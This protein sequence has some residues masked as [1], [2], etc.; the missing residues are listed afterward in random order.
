MD[1]IL[2]VGI[3]L[4]TTNSAVAYIDEN[5]APRVIP[6]SEDSTLTPSVVLIDGDQVVVGEDAKEAM[7]SGDPNAVAFF[8]RTMG[9]RTSRYYLGDGDYSAVDLST[10]VLKKLKADAEAYLGREVTHAVIT[11]PAYFNDPQRNDT[12][13]AGKLAGIE[14]LEII[15][16]PTAAGF[17][18]GLHETG[19]EETILV[20]D[21]GGGTFDVTVVRLSQ[22]QFTALGTSGDH[23]LGGKDWDDSIARLIIEK[24][25]QEFSSNPLQSGLAFGEVLVLAE[26]AKR[27]LTGVDTTTITLNHAGNQLRFDLT[28]EEFERRTLD[29]L[30]T[31]RSLS[32]S[33]L[34]EIGLS[35]TDLTGVLLVGGSTRMPMIAEFIQ[36]VS[37]KDPLTG[38]NQDHAVAIGAA[39]RAARCLDERSPSQPR[40]RLPGP[41]KIIDVISHPL[42]MIAESQD[43]SKYVNS[44][45]LNK[46]LPIPSS[47]TRPYQLF[48]QS[49][50]DNK[51]E[52]F[53]TQGE[54]TDPAD[55]TVIARWEATGIEHHSDGMQIIDV[56]YG[57]TQ[58]GTVDV[59]ASLRSNGR[60]LAMIKDEELGDLSWM[61]EAPKRAVVSGHLTVYM[62]ID[63]SYSME[64]SGLRTA[65]AAARS[66][67]KEL[68]MSKSSVG[69]VEFADRTRIVCDA[70]QNVR[71]LEGHIAAMTEH[72]ESGAVGFAN[73]ATPLAKIQPAFQGVDGSKFIIVLTDGIWVHQDRAI[74]EAQACHRDGIEIIAVGT[75][76]ADEAFLKRL[77]SSDSNALYA[78]QGQVV[79]TFNTIARELTETGGGAKRGLRLK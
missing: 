8:K 75:D 39:V 45:I 65:Q 56:E 73:D 12:I 11:V 42:G 13:K 49:D 33:M 58:N 7:R 70:C 22:D 62:A 14:V 41:A 32:E 51:L 18:Y 27:K 4:G 68:D 53:L 19:R 36:S 38:I 74:Q 34:K 77:A 40:F 57:Y 37:G 43:G 35:W 17:A 67:L 72:L 79:S 26:N 10:F 64:G 21:L 63:L 54:T 61:F 23:Q 20:Y 5:S 28:R 15:N 31:T 60:Q 3:D 78:Q 16:E 30:E 1:T 66:F 52:V 48:T 29:L 44:V 46:N 76:F 24:Y 69:L 50:G 71:T 9:D 59:K 6:N 2:P 55:C 25:T 47:D